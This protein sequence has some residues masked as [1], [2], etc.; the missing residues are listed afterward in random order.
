[1]PVPIPFPAD[2]PEARRRFRE[3]IAAAGWR[4]EWCDAGEPGPDGAPLTVD[5]GMSPDP[6]SHVLVVSSGLHGVE[7]PFGSAVQCAFIDR[8]RQDR[9]P[10]GVRVVLL[11][12]LNPYGFAAGRRCDADNVDPNRGFHWPGMP[13]RPSAAAYA[14][15]DA[16]LNPA[17]APGGV[18]LFLPRLLW[19]AARRGRTTLRRA[20]ATGQDAFPRGIF[21]AGGGPCRTQRLLDVAL[22]R[23][24]GSPDV[25]VHLDLHTGLGAWA[26]RR[27]IADYP[28]DAG[29]RAAL[30]RIFGDG[31][32]A[33]SA[34]DDQAYTAVGSLGQWCVARR[35]APRYLF[36]F[37]EFGTCGDLRVLAGLRAENRAH[38]WGT[39]AD[40]RR[41]RRRLREMFAPSSPDW[42]ARTVGDALAV[43]QGA[44]EAL[45]REASRPTMQHGSRVGEQGC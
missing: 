16:L 21:Y 28:L 23:W 15:L 30:A 6:A 38:H 4:H 5:V 36:V 42:R 17:S 43:I 27:L 22:P 40:R 20:L 11:H 33:E 3:A 44:A 37:A 32:I 39:E 13:R 29:G 26:A 18:D 41:A 1:M 10:R 14:A 31:A 12:A 7:G 45:G 2:Y 35:L 19:A 9:V 34:L 8:A 24:L 25:V